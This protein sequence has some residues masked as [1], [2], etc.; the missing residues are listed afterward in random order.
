MSNYSQRVPR[1]SRK[2]KLQLLPTKRER[3]DGADEEETIETKPNVSFAKLGLR[4]SRLQLTGDIVPPVKT[5]TGI[6][7]LKC[8]SSE[9]YCMSSN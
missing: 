4:A 5:S 1:P 8:N 7:M 3:G 6:T 9:Y 2:Q